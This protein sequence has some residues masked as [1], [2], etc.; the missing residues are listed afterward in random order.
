MILDDLDSDHDGFVEREEASA[1][2]LEVLDADRNGRVE[3]KEE[4]AEFPGVVRAMDSNG[5]GVVL[6]AEI[7]AF[8][9]E[10]DGWLRRVD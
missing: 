6:P 1:R 3:Q 9:D 10:L 7:R 8:Y 4:P 5:D 2:L